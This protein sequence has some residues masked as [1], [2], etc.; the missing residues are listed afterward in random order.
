MKKIFYFYHTVIA[1]LSLSIM[2]TA[3]SE[4][5]PVE[6]AKVVVTENPNKPVSYSIVGTWAYLYNGEPIDI[7]IFTA[8]GD[9]R[10]IQTFSDGDQEEDSGS[11][12]YDQTTGKLVV[13]WDAEYAW[14]YVV[15]EIDN[16]RLKLDHYYNGER[17]GSTTYFKYS[18][19]IPKPIDYSDV[20]NRA[21]VN[22]TYNFEYITL[23]QG[24]SV[25]YK[26][27]TNDL[28]ANYNIQYLG[29]KATGTYTLEG[30]KLTIN[31]DEVSVDA[32]GYNSDRSSF[33]GFDD[34][35][36]CTKK[37]T[38]HSCDG[39][40]LVMEDE[41]NVECTYVRAENYTPQV[42]GTDVSGTADGHDYVDL[43]LSV[44]W[45]TS[46]LG[47]TAPQDYGNNIY[48]FAE[49]SSDDDPAMKEWGGKWRLPT[50]DEV[51][52]L[53]NKCT[54]KVLH[55]NTDHQNLGYQTFDIGY[56]VTGP[57]GKNIYFSDEGTSFGWV[58]CLT[59]TRKDDSQYYALHLYLSWG[60]GIIG[61][62]A[63]SNNI[64]CLV[65]PVL[66]E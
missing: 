14:E 10:R 53:R 1:F 60:T 31:F 44:K 57:N 54:I 66:A 27:L 34:G 40:T 15:K 61:Y 19:E 37:Y 63:Y 47:A 23:M 55:S 36:S 24:R 8:N 26:W 9:F 2:I 12:T 39:N 6:D 29:A 43:G 11:Y 38:I 7:Y 48:N 13:R 17:M 65:R 3:C 18:G 22:T 50:L 49:A 20:I 56:V 35:K 62:E 58:D 21:W 28:L 45:A 51:K 64:K 52:E 30:S 25:D 41:D 16:E 32:Y 33:H 46:Y 5:D 59:G 42:Y 4:N